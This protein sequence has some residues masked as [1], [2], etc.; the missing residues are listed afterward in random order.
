MS[1]FFAGACVGMSQ[2]LVGHPFDTV[3]VLIQNRKGWLGLPLRSYYR[4][5]RFPFAAATMFNCTVFPIY[6]RT[7]PYTDNSL[8]S[9]CA[10]G[11]AV[12]PAVFCSE[13]GKIRRQT[14][15]P[16]SLRTYFPSKGFGATLSRETLAMSAYFGIYDYL[17]RKEYPALISGGLAGLANWTLTY[18][19]D[20]V[21]CR[22]IA[23]NIT[24]KEALRQKNLWRGYPVC[25]LR[26]VIVNAVNFWVYENAKK[27]L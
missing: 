15:Q 27:Y 23:Q 7:L 1:D 14:Q 5:W 9:G 8:L 19:I 4:G 12:T 13:I 6:E 25:G 20:V 2:V 11:I 21:K 16:L 22:Q 3:K 18:P 10:A 24:I 17:K 26:A